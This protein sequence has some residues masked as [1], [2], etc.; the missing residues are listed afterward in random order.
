MASKVQVN[1]HVPYTSRRSTIY[2]THYMAASTQSLASQA[3]V[4]ILEQGG[5]AADAAVAVAA[6]LGVTEPFSTGLGGDCFCL[7]YRVKDKT[8]YA[9]NGSGRAPAEL[10][11]ERLA[12]EFGIAGDAIPAYS[13]HAATVPGAAAAW[14]DT[15][16]RFGSGKLDLTSILGPAIT[17]A[18][19][20]FP[21]GEL[22]SPF[23]RDR[24]ELL[25]NASPNGHE[26]LINSEGPRAGEIFQNP[27]LAN[28]L[29]L[30]ARD[31]A[32][33]FYEGPVADAIVKSL[34]EK[35]GVMT[36]ADLLAHQSTFE[37]PISYEFHGYRL[38]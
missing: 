2:G 27:G 28:T 20:G 6:A 1:A 14:V 4:A 25:L 35:G 29:R 33:G 5:N 26:L 7:Y 8:V 37:D 34:Q 19:D 3:G 30:L 12:S 15:V 10:T 31:G 18:E 21:V 17:L 22:T 32:R 23:W 16:L 13:V 36:H 38:H 11:I 24:A 9:L